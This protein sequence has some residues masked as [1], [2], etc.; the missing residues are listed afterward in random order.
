MLN[1]DDFFLV[2]KEVLAHLTLDIVNVLKQLGKLPQ[3]LKTLVSL[4]NCIHTLFLKM[5][6][7]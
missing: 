2:H 5:V 1:N 3:T 7:N 6:T 4:C